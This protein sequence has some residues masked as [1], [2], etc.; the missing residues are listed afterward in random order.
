[1]S[2]V[3][4]PIAKFKDPD[5]IRNAFNNI[6]G[7]DLKKQLHQ[8]VYIKLFVHVFEKIIKL[9]IRADPQLFK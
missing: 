7:S 2:F 6:G 4:L 1:L 3:I 5:P 9:T 8:L